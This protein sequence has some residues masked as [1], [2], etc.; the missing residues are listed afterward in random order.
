MVSSSEVVVQL[1]G[2]ESAE[3][4]D[5][6]TFV[7]RAH[8]EARKG[9]EALPA[10]VAP[11]GELLPPEYRE[12]NW[13]QSVKNA[14]NWVVEKVAG[15]FDVLD[16]VRKIAWDITW[17]GIPAIVQIPVLKFV[18]G[19]VEEEARLSF[20]IASLILNI[21]WKIFDIEH[22][23]SKVPEDRAE[24]T[25]S[26]EVFRR[27]EYKT[28]L[29]RFSGVKFLQF[30]TAMNNTAY[31]VQFIK[32]MLASFGGKW[33]SWLLPPLEVLYRM[34]LEGLIRN[35]YWGTGLGWITWTTISPM[36]QATVGELLKR[37]YFRRFRP[38]LPNESDVEKAYMYGIIDYNTLKDYY[39]FLGYADEFVSWK[40]QTLW[41]KV[42]VADAIDA[43]RRDLIDLDTLYKVL[44][45]HGYNTKDAWLLISVSR[46]YLTPSQYVEA[47][48]RG[49]IEREP[50]YKYMFIVGYNASE[51]DLLY[52]LDFKPLSA[53]DVIEAWHRGIIP[54]R[55]FYD[56]M[57]KAGYEKD[58]ADVL[59]ELS[60]RLLS[61]TDLKELFLRGI[62]DTKKVLEVLRARG[63][64]DEDIKL[65]VETWYR[66]L[67]VG[68]V[69]D[70]WH[71]GIV[72]ETTVDATLKAYGYKD[73]EI[74]VL[75]EL[76]YKP[77]NETDI[78]ELTLKGKIDADETI[79]RLK[80]LGYSESDIP[81]VIET[82]Y[83]TLSTSDALEAWT[84]GLITDEQLGELLKANG[85]RTFEQGIL[86]QL[87][88]KLPPLSAVK[89]AY[90]NKK[91]TLRF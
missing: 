3:V 76:S 29:A 32:D 15:F 37:Y 60:W 17:E 73:E 43:W 26:S 91:K 4:L 66:V 89:A 31:T 20:W 49:L 25:A 9:L 64:K 54:A 70:A 6:D 71:R 40:E 88:K 12:E 87:S 79:A 19:N 14:L 21:A 41:K 52:K 48:R 18:E 38:I 34:D 44:R 55:E 30:I 53:A 56:Y 90:R 51:A 61:E 65:L 22:W 45:A 8:K 59:L 16:E 33:F 5:Y 86:R 7:E 35:I 74:K 57:R 27:Y 36:A 85:Y 84:R 83:K 68:D 23:R 2:Y 47:Y 58:E 1:L 42:P 50:F 13:T 72:S 81:K 28:E 63:Y 80:A 24:L 67:A 46:K 82:W 11:P 75:K 62:I 39:S 77:L 78:K 10:Y 69:L